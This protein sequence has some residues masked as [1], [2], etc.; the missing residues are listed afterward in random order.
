MLTNRR[1]PFEI[2]YI[3][4]MYI[5]FQPVTSLNFVGEDPGSLLSQK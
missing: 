1:K 4:C 5:V 3:N 2:I